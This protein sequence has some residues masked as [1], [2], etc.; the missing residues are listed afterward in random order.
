[1]GLSN[2]GQ[3]DPRVAERLQDLIT[4]QQASVRW[5]WRLLA[6]VVVIAAVTSAVFQALNYF[7]G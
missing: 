6:V 1:M 3:P 5:H 4:L 7:I 2:P